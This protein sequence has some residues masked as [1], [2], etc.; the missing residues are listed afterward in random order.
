M[1]LFLLNGSMDGLLAK[2]LIRERSGD[3]GLLVSE[4]LQHLA[5]MGTWHFFY[6]VV[7][8]TD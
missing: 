1:L 3:A 5:A 7:F 6:F 8:V 4:I 2:A